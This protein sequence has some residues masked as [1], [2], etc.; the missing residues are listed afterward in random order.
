MRITT[1][2]DR[3]YTSIEYTC[4]V[5]MYEISSGNFLSSFSLTTGN[6]RGLAFDP[7]GYLHVSTWGKTVEVFNYQ[8]TNGK[9]LPTLSS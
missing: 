7:S 2:G 1:R 6:A 5:R 3:L 8:D 9:K 4:N